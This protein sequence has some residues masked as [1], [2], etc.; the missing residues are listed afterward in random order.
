MPY[1]M[2]VERESVE[3]VNKQID[4]GHGVLA[5]GVTRAVF[6][7]STSAS[8][9]RPCAELTVNYSNSNCL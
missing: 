9:S 7:T 4:A 5:K 8:F 2:E 6:Y 3:G 1:Y